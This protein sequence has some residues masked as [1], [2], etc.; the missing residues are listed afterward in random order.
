MK[1]IGIGTAA[2]SVPI[3]SSCTAKAKDDATSVGYVSDAQSKLI[4][5]AG[6]GLQITGTFLDE[7]S[8]DISHQ[9]WGEKEW[10][11][12]FAHMKAIGIDTV[13]MIRSGYR[14]FITYPSEY[15]LKKGCY[16]PSVDLVYMY[17]RLVEK[18][19][20]KFWIG[21]YDSGHYWDT[22]DLRHEIEDNK[23]V[24]DRNPEKQNRQVIRVFSCLIR[25]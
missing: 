4:V 6:A 13:I 16:K 9:N 17:L 15:L 22:G 3:L 14:K 10:D 20:I 7:I 18:H 21:L 12:D 23:Y 24:I 11:Q 8:H 25:V 19:G 2:V 1:K 5:P